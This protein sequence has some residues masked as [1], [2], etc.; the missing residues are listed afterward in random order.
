MEEKYIELLIQKCTDLEN[1]KTLFLHYMKEARPFVDKI[2]S[3]VNKMGVEDI[4]LEEEDPYLIHDEL[5]RMTLE[6]IEKSPYFNKQMWDEYAKKKA[7]FIILESEYPHLMDDV[8]PR[9]IGLSAKLK[10]STK[11]LYRELQQKCQLS[12]VIAAYPSVSWAKDLFGDDPASYDTLKNYIFKMCMIDT[13]DPLA[14]WDCILNKNFTVMKKLNHLNIEKLHYQNKLG[15]DLEIYLPDNYLYSSAKDNHVIVNM[16]SYEVF[17]SPVYNKTNGI[18][19]SSKP[20]NYNG[21]MIDHFW[22][23]FAEGKVVDYDA[24]IGKEVLKEIIETDEYSCFLGEAALVE[25]DSPIEQ[26]NLS[27]H[28]TLIDENA[29]CHLALGAAFPECIVDGVNMSEEELRNLGLNFSSQHVDFMIGTD[30]LSITA[31][32]K[33]MKVI[34]IFEDGKFTEDILN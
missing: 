12:W 32:T 9:K 17:T 15:T 24:K 4:Y 34:K 21:A 20:L 1:N 6:E 23:R 18:V 13:E 30:D 11:P 5:E 28:T 33:D 29:S 26:L 22:I 31:Y 27:F 10:R 7:S 8:D 25:K 19:Y 2:I 16:P 14:S 3:Y